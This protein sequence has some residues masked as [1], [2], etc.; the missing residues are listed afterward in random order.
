MSAIDRL[1]EEW[2]AWVCSDCNPDFN[3]PDPNEPSNSPYEKSFVLLLPKGENAP[4]Y[5]PRCDSY[6]S[7][8]EGSSGLRV[9][10]RPERRAFEE[11]GGGFPITPELLKRLAKLEK[12]KDEEEK[13]AQS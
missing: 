13:Q 12:E 1:D 5:C 8:C 4:D 9:V 2:Q 6:L 10:S 3:D 11:V 7:M